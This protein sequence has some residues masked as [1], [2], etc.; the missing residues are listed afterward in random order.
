MDSSLITTQMGSYWRRALNKDKS[1]INPTLVRKYTTST[2]QEMY[3]TKRKQLICCD[4]LQ[5]AESKYAIFNK[6]KSAVGASNMVKDVQR[7][8]LEQ[9]VN[10]D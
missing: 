3:Q 7:R 9:I 4:N 2:I 5:M 1:K 6:Q 10:Y 8:S